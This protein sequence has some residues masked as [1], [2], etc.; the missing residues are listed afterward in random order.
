LL[1]IDGP[2]TQRIGSSDVVEV[3]SDAPPVRIYRPPQRSFFD[4][5]RTKLHW[6]I[7][8]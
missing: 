2:W 1:T 4:L 8:S 7:R 5:L 3:T 6:G